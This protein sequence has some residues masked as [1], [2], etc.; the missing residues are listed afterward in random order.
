MKNTARKAFLLS[1]LTCMLLTG[2]SFNTENKQNNTPSQSSFDISRYLDSNYTPTFDSVNEV[3][4]YAYF[5]KLKS[6]QNNG[7]SRLIKKAD[8]KEDEKQE[9]VRYPITATEFSFHNFLY[10]TFEAEEAFRDKQSEGTFDFID[11][12]VGLGTI[13]GLIVETSFSDKLLILKNNDKYFSCTQNGQMT[14]SNNENDYCYMDFMTHHYFENFED[15]KEP[16]SNDHVNI[17]F[18]FEDYELNPLDLTTIRITYWNN[19][20]DYYTV[21]KESIYYDEESEATCSIDELKEMFGVAEDNGES[22]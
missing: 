8:E 11:T 14:V 3:S 16:K 18:T 20:H 5:S 1:T 22:L 19:V 2:C 9:T 21:D 13:K 15:V 7:K 17:L 12:K 6:Q 10:F 4:Y